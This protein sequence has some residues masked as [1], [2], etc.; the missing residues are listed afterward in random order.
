MLELYV[1]ANNLT[2][3]VFNAKLDPASLVVDRT[4]FRWGNSRAAALGGEAL[5]CVAPV[6]EASAAVAR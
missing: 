1:A 4:R 3:A 2:M 5:C 6:P